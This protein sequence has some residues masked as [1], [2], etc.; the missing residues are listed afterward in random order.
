[1]VGMRCIVRAVL[2]RMRLSSLDRFCDEIDSLCSIRPR[3][4][5]RSEPLHTHTSR[6]AEIRGYEDRREIRKEKTDSSEHTQNA[7]GRK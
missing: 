2:A 4:Q 5:Q 1:M 3:V 7:E 6:P